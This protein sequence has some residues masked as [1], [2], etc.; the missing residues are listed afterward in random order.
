MQ[1]PLAKRYTP[2]PCAV[3]ANLGQNVSQRCAKQRKAQRSAA[4]PLRMRRI[5]PYGGCACDVPR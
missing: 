2:P 3:K 4:H 5:V 1:R